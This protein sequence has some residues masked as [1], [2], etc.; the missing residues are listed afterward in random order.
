MPSKI[1]E[2][3]YNLSTKRPSEQEDTYQKNQRPIALTQQQD[4]KKERKKPFPSEISSR[5]F[6]RATLKNNPK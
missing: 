6:V 1:N 5:L 3:K 4:I 2:I